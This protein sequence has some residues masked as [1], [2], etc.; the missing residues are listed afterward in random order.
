[1]NVR[2]INPARA[3]RLALIALAAILTLMSLVAAARRHL[4]RA[5]LADLLDRYA[6]ATDPTA[7]NQPATQSAKDGKSKAGKDAGKS[8]TAAR[9]RVKRICDRRIFSPAKPK[10]GFSATLVGVLGDEAFFA[11]QKKGYKV[12]QS[13]SG[14]KILEI[15]PD[16]V[17]LDVKGKDKTLHVFGKGGAGSSPRG[18]RGP[19]RPGPSPAGPV[20]AGPARMPGP[21][22]DVP[23]RIPM[24]RAERA[25][26]AARR[27]RM[28]V[29]RLGSGSDSTSTMPAPTSGPAD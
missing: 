14:A 9:D 16:W 5:E 12:G 1:M 20:M 21:G 19:S 2:N 26:F 3:G 13:F 10:R 28:Y 27:K 24:S 18:P 17:K 11:G 25:R 15:G 7:G 6:A 23:V 4:G 22:P 29:V 8:S